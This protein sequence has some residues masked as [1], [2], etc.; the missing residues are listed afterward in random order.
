LL[1]I[2]QSPNRLQTRIDLLGISSRHVFRATKRGRR[3]LR[4]HRTTMSSRINCNRRWLLFSDQGHPV[5]AAPRSRPGQEMVPVLRSTQPGG[6][7]DRLRGGRN[8]TDIDHCHWAGRGQ[9]SAQAGLRAE[10]RYGTNMLPSSFS[11]SRICSRS[12][13]FEGFLPVLVWRRT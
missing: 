2:S 10:I 8:G 13:S 1:T 7:R 12:S 3:S 11:Q 4:P 9:R 5:F 6:G